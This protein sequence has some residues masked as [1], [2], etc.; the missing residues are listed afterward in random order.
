MSFVFALYLEALAV[1]RGVQGWP[2][3]LKKKLALPEG[4]LNVEFK[5]IIR[6]CF[7]Q[8]MIPI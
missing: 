1:L 3:P 8:M 5:I 6:E 4:L 2:M 7:L